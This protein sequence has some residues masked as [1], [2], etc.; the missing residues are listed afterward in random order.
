V[1]LLV[2]AGADVNAVNKTGIN[3]LTMALILTNV[4]AAEAL[5]AKGGKLTPAQ[6]TMLSGNTDPRVKALIQKASKK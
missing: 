1:N 3:P 5:I 2:T 6:V 4:N